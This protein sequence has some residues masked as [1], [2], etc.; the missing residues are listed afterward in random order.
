MLYLIIRY[1]AYFSISPSPSALNP[2]YAPALCSDI[3]AD[4]KGEG[5]KGV[6]NLPVSPISTPPR[7][8]KIKKNKKIKNKKYDTTEKHSSLKLWHLKDNRVLRNAKFRKL[9]NLR[10]VQLFNGQR[11]FATAKPA[12]FLR[13]ISAKP[14]ILRGIEPCSLTKTLH[15]GHS[16][17]LVKYG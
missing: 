2:V 10:I 12:E 9:L 1:Y 16:R 6:T 15:S 5:G 3:G 14:R 11:Y 4:L 17:Y 13:K 8:K 7:L